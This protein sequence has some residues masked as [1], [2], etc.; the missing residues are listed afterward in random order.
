MKNNLFVY[1]CSF[2]SCYET[3]PNHVYYENYKKQGDDNWPNIVA[4]EFDLTLHNYGVGLYSN[5]KIFDSIMYSWDLIQDGDIVIIE[6]S[7][8]HR[9]DIPNFTDEVLLTISPNP[10]NLLN[11]LYVKDSEQKYSEEEIE[12]LD[13]ITALMDSELIR[14]RHLDRF[15]FIEKII[16]KHK[17]VKCLLWDIGIENDG[18]YENINDATNGEI[19]DWHWSFKG[20]KDFSKFIIDS[21]NKI[22]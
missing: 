22:T 1:G 7:Y 18:K 13:Y 12:H 4:N 16:K 6:M 2:T 8:F 17:T 15:M 10:S 3:R 21:I 14:K 20:N 11:N 9:F 19:F 5:D